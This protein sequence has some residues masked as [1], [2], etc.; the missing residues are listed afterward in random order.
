VC[1]GVIHFSFFHTEMVYVKAFHIFSNGPFF[2]IWNISIV[3]SM[4]CMC[5]VLSKFGQYDTVSVMN[6]VA[7]QY[8]ET[9]DDGLHD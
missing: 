9:P 8:S 2:S 1:I 4:C 7:L 3:F 6:V 5:V